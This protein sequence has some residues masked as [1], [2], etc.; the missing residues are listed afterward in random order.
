MLD[1]ALV[2]DAVAHSYDF[3]DT[4]NASGRYSQAVTDLIPQARL[5]VLPSGHAPWL[6]QPA[7]TAAAVADFLRGDRAEVA[8]AT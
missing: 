6:G 1:G 4:N 5:Q 2:I 8:Y 3:R 7:Q